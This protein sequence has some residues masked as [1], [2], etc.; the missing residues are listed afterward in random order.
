MAPIHH[1]RCSFFAAV[2][3]RRSGEHMGEISI[4]SRKK[5]GGM[6]QR[7]EQLKIFALKEE[8]VRGKHK[9]NQF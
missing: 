2:V 1:G 7:G 5:K 9:G 3:L 6:K 4:W 8:E